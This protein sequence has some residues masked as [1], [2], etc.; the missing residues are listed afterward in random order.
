MT[1]YQIQLQEDILKVDFGTIPADGDRIVRDAVT[2]VREMIASGEIKGGNLLK[3]NGRISI[4]VSYAL[5][6]ELVHLYRAIALA[7]TRLGAYIV[8]ISTASEYPIGSRIDF[9]TGEV[10]LVATNSISPPSFLIYWENDVLIAKINNGIQVDG[11]QILIDAEAQLKNLINSGQLSGGEQLLING[12]ATNLASIVIAS[13]VAHLY[14]T[15]AVFDPKV[16]AKGLDRYVVVIS[17]GEK[18]RSGDIVDIDR[19]SQSSIKVVLCG[20]PN[21]GKTVL[22][23]G[24]KAAIL[25]LK[26]APDDFYAISGCPDGDGSWHGETMAKYPDLARELKEEYKRK[27]T[28]EF[29]ITKARE[30][31]VIKNSLLLFD[32]GGKI[33]TYEDKDIMAGATHAVILA[34]TEEDVIAWQE[35]CEKHLAQYL[36]IIAILYS[37][38][39]GKNDEIISES[40]ILIGKVHYLERGEDI[41]NRPMVQALAKVIVDLVVKMIG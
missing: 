13:K 15:V 9:T 33:P 31:R 19:Q 26:N 24:L 16:G 4:L 17:H 39:H 14:R 6:H 23:D 11:D 29:A 12:R 8:A 30:I 36:P 35:V 2:R 32:V 41:S 27:F 18:Y 37:D 3:I 28:P 21:T 7:D 1:T 38:F 10:K 22:R 40:P 25:K 20:F 5:A 34:K